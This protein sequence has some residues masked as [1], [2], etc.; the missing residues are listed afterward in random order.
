MHTARANRKA[1]QKRREIA[2]MKQRTVPSDRAIEPVDKGPAPTYKDHD[3]PPSRKLTSE[4]KSWW[5]RK[6]GRLFYPGI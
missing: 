4:E 2:A 1:N 6:M 5:R 3:K